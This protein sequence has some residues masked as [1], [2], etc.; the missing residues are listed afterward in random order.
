MSNKAI[1]VSTDNATWYTLPGNTG[2]YTDEL[3]MT[4]DTV[5]GQTFESQ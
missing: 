4:K 1:Q 3:N 2:S 5:F